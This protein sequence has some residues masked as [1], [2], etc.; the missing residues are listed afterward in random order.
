M[1][2]FKKDKST[3]EQKPA[4]A[5]QGDGGQMDQMV[6]MLA[7]APE[8]QRVAMLNDRLAV[9][10]DQEQGPREDTM[11]GMLV[12][13][14]KLPD[15]EYQKIAAA[16]FKALQSF[17]SDTQMM[18]MKSHAAVVKALPGDQRAK[19]MSAMKKI[20]SGLPEDKRAQ[21]MTMM[22]NLGLMG[23]DA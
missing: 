7:S 3:S 22:Q 17:P 11:R 2:W 19:D 9:F 13:A 10:A 8:E 12:A 4:V 21:M 16:R 20:I 14:L 18:L 23:G 5:A 15:D 1:S 6:R